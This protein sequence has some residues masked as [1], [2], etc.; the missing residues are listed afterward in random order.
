MIASS[1]LIIVPASIVAALMI[2]CSIKRLAFRDINN[3]DDGRLSQLVAGVGVTVCWVA[4][5]VR[6]VALNDDFYEQLCLVVIAG[7]C[8]LAVPYAYFKEKLYIFGFAMVGGVLAVMSWCLNGSAVE[9]LV[10][11]LGALGFVGTVVCLPVGLAVAPM[12]WLKSS[13][14]ERLQWL[15]V[16]VGVVMSVVSLGVA[17]MEVVEGVKRWVVIVS[18]DLPPYPYAHAV[19]AYQFWALLNGVVYLGRGGR[20]AALT[21]VAM[22]GWVSVAKFPPAVA[23]PIAS[24][25]GIVALLT[26][27][28]WY[29]HQPPKTI[30]NTDEENI[31]LLT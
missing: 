28:W 26:S 29:H 12:R 7:W 19:L 11:A 27:A 4:M 6:V 22:C 21:G 15:V 23:V 8:W 17:L 1:L 10:L 2:A 3:D 30:T 31:R 25:L 16:P 24:A 18:F 14:N 13:N 20:L 9:F 5:L